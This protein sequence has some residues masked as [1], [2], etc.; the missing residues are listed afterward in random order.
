MVDY[1]FYIGTF[2]GGSISVEDWPTFEARAA[3]QLG[4]YKRIYTVTA[5]EGSVDA[6]SMAICAMADTLYF[7]A[8]AQS[9]SA[10]GGGVSSVSVGSVATS[11]GNPVAVS[12]LDVSPKAQTRE[13][14]RVACQY[15]DFYRGVG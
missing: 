9:G 8:V 6:E 15:L 5:P 4:R 10:G 7:Y 2:R 3:D 12:A 14:Y 13:L 1:D 11:Y